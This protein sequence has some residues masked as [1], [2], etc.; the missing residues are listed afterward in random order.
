MSWLG[1]N[2]FSHIGKYEPVKADI[3][4]EDFL[5]LSPWNID[6]KILHTPGH[7]NGSISV[8]TGNTIFAG[9]TFFNRGLKGT[10]PPFAN[11]PIILL[12]TWQKLFDLGIKEIYPGHGPKFNVKKAFPELEKWKRKVT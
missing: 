4:V 10:F 8:I 7:T 6:G 2:I 1:R 11:N 12:K 9:D 5:D 3:I